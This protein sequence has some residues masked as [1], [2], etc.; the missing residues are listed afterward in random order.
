MSIENAEQIIKLGSILINVPETKGRG[1]TLLNDLA[2]VLLPLKVAAAPTHAPQQAAPAPK[3]VETVVAPE[4]Q[5]AVTPDSVVA[6]TTVADAAPAVSP[7]P[8][9]TITVEQ[10]NAA[11]VEEFKRLG[12]RDGIDAAIKV[13]NNGNP[14]VT[15]LPPE[16]YAALIAAVKAL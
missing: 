3:P 10:L 16:Q 13:L 11:L 4:P 1:I 7:T 2:D 14:S 9:P 6:P 12:G 8:A 15:T 5:T